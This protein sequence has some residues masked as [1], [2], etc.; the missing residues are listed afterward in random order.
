MSIQDEYKDLEDRLRQSKP[1]TEPLPPAFKRQVRHELMEQMTMNDNRFSFRKL[2]MALGGL[3]L[4]VGI[5]VFFW[6]AQM[7][8]GAANNPGAASNPEQGLDPS[9]PTP[10]VA[11]GVL[12]EEGDTPVVDQAV[13]R[14]WLISSEPVEGETAGLHDTINVTVGYELVTVQEAELLVKLV[15]GPVGVL[16]VG[17]IV[18]GT[19]G[20]VVIPLS[21]AA[22][23]DGGE[24]NPLQ[25]QLLLQDPTPGVTKLLYLEFVE[26]WTMAAAEQTTATAEIIR[27]SKPS[28][29]VEEGLPEGAIFEVELTT[30]YTL[31]GYEE[32]LLVM[33]YEYVD[34]N[35]QAGSLDVRPISMG[36]GEI[37]SVFRMAGNLFDASGEAVEGLNFFARI[38]RYDETAGGWVSVY[39]GNVT[40]PE[41]ER[42]LPYPYTRDSFVIHS[43]AWE[44]NA[45]G[46]IILNVTMGYNL[47]SEETAD[48]TIDVT[49][50]DGEVLG[51]ETAV[52][53]TGQELLVVPLA[54]DKAVLEGNPTVQVSA[55]LKA[56]EIVI[57]DELQDVYVSQAMVSE[58]GTE[59]ALWIVSTDT[60]TQTT[61]NGVAVDII[62]VVGYDLSSEYESGRFTFS[63]Q[64]QTTTNSGGG[65]GGGGG[66]SPS[67]LSPGVGTTRFVFSFET[68]SWEAAQEQLDSTSVSVLL[69]GTTASGDE[70]LV[71]ELGLIGID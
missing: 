57:E 13:D 69:F 48:I 29:V 42:N 39:P 63:S 38:N 56:G 8:I 60:V 27:V 28:P 19:S 61:E 12:E 66:G 33:G 41:I 20:V 22:L 24:G 31:S 52:I 70:V 40:L 37:T 5:P 50:I 16:T 21:L 2:S 49:G 71:A 3:I 67:R 64:Y 53:T 43:A 46:Q 15:D 7:S 10:T 54:I 45:A 4:L 35:G 62:L 30:A 18:S 1:Q 34:A 58:G 47:E 59:N 17:K 26:G 14:A 55:V 68:S 44:E 25:L 23:E 6:L 65:G 36:S 32:A 11:A 9:R 51:S